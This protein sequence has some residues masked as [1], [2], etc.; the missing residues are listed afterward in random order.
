ME[1]CT[2]SIPGAEVPFKD[3]SAANLRGEGGVGSAEGWGRGGYWQLGRG[4]S[5]G[6]EV[7]R[8]LCHNSD[9]SSLPG[10]KS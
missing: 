1:T 8:Y 9:F 10:R 6:M 5:G 3:S 4:V 2:P 7:Q